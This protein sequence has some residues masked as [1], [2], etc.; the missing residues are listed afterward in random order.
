MSVTS[1]YQ[2]HLETPAVNPPKTKK[3]KKSKKGKGKQEEA[4]DDYI[5]SKLQETTA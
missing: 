4:E 5:P 3:G 2:T 1:F